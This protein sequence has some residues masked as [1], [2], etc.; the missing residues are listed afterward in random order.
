MSDEKT[1]VVWRDPERYFKEIGHDFDL[2]FQNNG[3][4]MRYMKGRAV[5]PFLMGDL[6]KKLSLVE[7]DETKDRQ[8]YHSDKSCL[9][10]RF[11]VEGITRYK[12]IVKDPD[13]SVAW[14]PRH[15]FT[16]DYIG[17][18]PLLVDCVY[19]SLDESS[20]SME[21]EKQSHKY[22]M[23]PGGDNLFVRGFS[24]ILK[25]FGTFMFLRKD[26]AFSLKKKDI[27]EINQNMPLVKYFIDKDGKRRM[28]DSEHEEN[29]GELETLLADKK[30][31][32]FLD[33]RYYLTNVLPSY[34]EQQMFEGVNGRTYDI[35]P[36][37]EY[38]IGVNGKVSTG[39]S[40]TGEL[41]DM[42]PL[43]FKHLYRILQRHKGEKELLIVPSNMSGSKY[44][45]AL[46]FVGKPSFLL[47]LSRSLKYIMDSNYF[48]IRYPH[49]AEKHPEAKIEAT[50]KFGEP[51]SLSEFNKKS[52]V[53]DLPGILRKRIGLLETPYPVAVLCK[54]MEGESEVLYSVLNE[55]FK[56]L[57]EYYQKLGI[58][59]SKITS[60]NGNP[61]DAEDLTERVA[62]TLNS[63]PRIYSKGGNYSKKII[64]PRQFS[65]RSNNSDLQVW[66][67]NML[68]HLEI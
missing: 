44:P 17:M 37:V 19:K 16:G 5:K 55:R 67:A 18:Q 51:I 25:K 53:D 24:T 63:N 33:E 32:Q 7:F 26:K 48:W 58:D 38:K 11:E 68:K 54:L 21:G 42:S 29:V 31:E 64:E 61:L 39:R 4:F 20:E 45:D 47:G 30:V 65:V 62:L 57:L 66:Y 13:I 49:Y 35:M 2:E 59:V 10:S 46:N 15:R 3:K 22:L 41:G 23:I 14:C 8:V 28:I 27:E 12:E 34:L 56:P 9:F 52:V 50:V 1:R 43:F 6:F 36:F 40:K 60:P